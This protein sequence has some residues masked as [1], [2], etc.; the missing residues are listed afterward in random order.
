MT[1]FH[2]SIVWVNCGVFSFSG[3]TLLLA[4]SRPFLSFTIWHS[5]DNTFVTVFQ[6]PLYY[7]TINSSLCTKC[8]SVSHIERFSVVSQSR[9]E[10]R[11][12]H[13]NHINTPRIG[14]AQV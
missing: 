1:W 7:R 5:R 6:H 11:S 9:R 10:F 13:E 12:F 8:T 4:T 14:K 2:V 3:S